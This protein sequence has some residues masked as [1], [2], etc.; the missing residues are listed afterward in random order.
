MNKILLLV[1]GALVALGV[2]AFVLQPGPPDGECVPDGQPS[3][4]YVDEESGCNISI[5]SFE[6]IMD[7]ESSPKWFRIA[8][9]LLVVAGVVTAVAAFVVGRRRAGD[10]GPPA[11]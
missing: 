3:S 6:E 5:E 10:P 11:P 9:L 7:H 8:G 1:A 4:G 2:V